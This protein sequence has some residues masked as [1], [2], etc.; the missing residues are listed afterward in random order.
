MA[1]SK[2]LK[3]ELVAGYVEQLKESQG[4]VVADYRGLN[5]QEMSDIRREMRP[6][7]GK[8][9]V[10]K[11]RLLALALEEVGL[12]VPDEW[13]TGP[14]AIGF[15]Y[16]EV[17]PVAKVLKDAMKEMETLRIKGGVLGT[18]VLEAE[19]VSTLAD[20]PS[21]EVLMAQLLG[22]INAPARR[23]AGA[24]AS[25]LRQVVNVLKAYADKLESGGAPNAEPVAEAA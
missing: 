3:K 13:L 11:N 15:C 1:I 19:R 12:S 7:D 14:T 6:V 21:R 4:I 20:L 17:P 22:T 24:M 5:V 8:F 2:E 25:G 23:V 18:S 16:D 9:T 10:I